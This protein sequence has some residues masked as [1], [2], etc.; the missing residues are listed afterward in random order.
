MSSKPPQIKKEEEEQEE[1][2]HSS[3]FRVYMTMVPQQVLSLLMLL[4]QHGSRKN[5]EMP[6]ARE[7]EEVRR[8]VQTIDGSQSHHQTLEDGKGSLILKR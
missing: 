2:F 4:G 6:W 8:R 7:T 3:S 5:L 1:L